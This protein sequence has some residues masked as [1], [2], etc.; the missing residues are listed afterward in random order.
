LGDVLKFDSFDELNTAFQQAQAKWHQ[1]NLLGA[2]D[3]LLEIFTYRL[4]YAKLIDA[5]LKVIQTLAD[6]AGLLGEFQA[7]D[8]L[9]YGA[10]AQYEQANSQLQA[11]Y[12]RLRRVQ[13]LLDRGDLHQARHQLQ[14][15]AVRIGDIESIQF[16]PSGLVQWELGCV[17][18]DTEPQERTIVFAELYL[19]MGRLLSALGQF[20]D[21]LKA[22]HRG[23]FHTEGKEVP[24]LARQTVIPLKLAMATAL[25]EGG[26]LED[27]DTHL[28]HLQTELDEPQH[29]EHYINCLEISGKLHLLRGDL[30]KALETF[31][32]VQAKCRQLAAGRAVL[33]SDLNLAHVLILLNQTSTAQH[34]L[35]DTKEY[36][37]EIQDSVLAS[38]AQLLLNLA[39]VRGRSLVVGTPVGLSVKGM[40]HQQQ[41]NQP[42]A[43]QEAKLD[44]RQSP[45]YLTWF[46]DRALAFQW[47]LSDLNLGMAAAL[48]K[49]IQQAF[50]FTDSR[51][52]QVQ[53]Q[54]L[55]GI[56]AYYQGMKSEDPN[57][58]GSHPN[59]GGIR[60]ANKILEKVRPQLEEIGLKP[61][62]W[63]VQRILGWC[64]ARLNYPAAEQEALTRSTNALLTQLTESLS[65]ED[66]AIYLLNKWTA[67]EEYIAA[68]TNQL[69]RLQAKLRA[70]SPL[71]RPWRRWLLMQRLN[72]LVEHIDRYKD[73]LV[74]RTIQGRKV[75]VK[76]EPTSSLWQRL[77]THPKN[78]VTLSFLVLPDRVFVVRAWKFFLDFAVIPTTRLE[79]RNVVQHWHKRIQR[80]NG[81]RDLSAMPDDDSY[82]SVMASV[83]NEGKTIANQLAEILDIPS[84]LKGLPKNTRSLT[85]VPDD[86]L[87]GFP[88]ATI[89]HQGKYL[90]EHYALSIA[91]ESSGKKSPTPS[92]DRSQK[93][94]IVGVSQETNQ[95]ASLPA[96]GKELDQVERWLIR[97]HIDWQT[98]V[99][100][101]ARKAA[102]LEGLSEATLLHIACHGTFEHNRPDQSGLVLISN[103]ENREILSL[104]EL[105]NLN[106]T[107][108]RHATLSSCWSA[109]HFILPGRWIISL[110]ETLWRSG[111]ESILG[112]LWEVYDKVAVSFMTRFYDYLEELPR[113]EALRRTQLDCL[114]GRLPD[115]GTIDTTNPIFWAGFNLYGECTTLDIF[116]NKQP[117]K[118]ENSISRKQLEELESARLQLQQMQ[119]EQRQL[120]QTAAQHL[121]ELQIAR[122]RIE[123]LEGEQQTLNNRFQQQKEDLKHQ[124][125]L[126]ALKELLDVVDGFELARQQIQ[127]NSEQQASIHQGYEGIYRLL[128]TALKR[129]GVTEINAMGHPFDPNLHEA[130]MVEA[131][132]QQADGTVLAEIRRGYLLGKLVLRPAQVKV[133]I[134]SELDSN[135]S[136][137]PANGC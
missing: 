111:V 83:A 100:N 120:K 13:I 107:E 17:W 52:I 56:F 77:L 7:A 127:T 57:R 88:F 116:L 91:Y 81:G 117:R 58:V 104:R 115:C 19:A 1:G 10:I 96:V 2:Y 90:V 51:L 75:D 105:S 103:S 133:A 5:D 59:L 122:Q 23:L 99:D 31:R 66:Q 16:S 95:F 3:L 135:T 55:E 118:L 41:D 137:T 123:Q 119:I 32:Q 40:L 33:R 82:E 35:E 49:Q 86:I 30:G 69:Q 80:I 109:D 62:L 53:I 67:D 87:H 26:D 38:R 36:A 84:L 129:I 39:S 98:L 108:L 63:Q 102:I 121:R 64:R 136:E 134:G 61:E 72:A 74:K 54:V 22:L 97:H 21:A 50:K 46:E 130:V 27:A 37:L 110:P 93:A 124:G 11:D 14:V 44:L 45:N 112:C 113:D 34:Y 24:A 15:M 68:E 92:C 73:V 43:H 29:P 8:D 47:Q 131:S 9:L 12:T 76:H 71:L 4:L 79:V 20:G 25:L 65:P 132:E 85:I 48:L 114:Q 106:L 6:L 101:S 94:L 70:G 125:K 126:E 89:V 42:V 28:T 18:L 60:Q 78:R 128:V